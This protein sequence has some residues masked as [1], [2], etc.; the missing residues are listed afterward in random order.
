MISD[1]LL[2]LVDVRI[3]FYRLYNWP[4]RGLLM[5]RQRDNHQTYAGGDNS[6]CADNESQMRSGP[7]CGA[8]LLSSIVQ[9]SFVLTA[10]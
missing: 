1:R 3:R 2:P 9:I 7:E 5:T 10:V 4:K 8:G 6:L